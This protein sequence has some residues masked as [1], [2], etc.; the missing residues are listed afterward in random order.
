M[1]S[2]PQGVAAARLD[3]HVSVGAQIAPADVAALARMGFRAILSNRP[4]GEAPDQPPFAEIAAAARKHGMEAV[5]QPVTSPVTEA[6]ADAFAAELARLPGPV[7]AH[8]RSGTRSA[9][10]WALSQRGTR[11]A[12]EIVAGARA[13]GYD[14]SGLADRL[15]RA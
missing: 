8:C 6:D 12:D 4:D 5:H 1:G 11:P 13:A 9:T 10:L 14:L 2:D 15:D 7:F 3:D